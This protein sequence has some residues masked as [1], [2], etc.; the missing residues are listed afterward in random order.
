[1]LVVGSS[2]SLP[3]NNEL[4]SVFQATFSGQI[5]FITSSTLAKAATLCLMMRLF[6]LN[7]PTASTH[8]RSPALLWWLCITILISIALWGVL[9]I[10]ALSVDC[11]ASH[12]IRAGSAAQCSN[13]VD[14]SPTLL[15][16][17]G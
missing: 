2:G 12:F 3:V 10:I 7:S 8:T 4:M 9:S 6:N 5:L 14:S 17:F 11:S 13:Q 1:M 15:V 16:P